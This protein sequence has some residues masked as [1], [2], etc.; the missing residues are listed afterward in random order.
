MKRR[1]FFIIP[2]LLQSCSLMYVPSVRSIPLLEE[3][4]EFQGE[5]GTSLNSIYANTAY[6][7]TD[8]IAA[9][10]SGNM[11]YKNFSNR[12]TLF[13]P[14]GQESAGE[15]AHRYAEAS[16]GA[17]NMLHSETPG[18]PILEIFGGMG[19]GRATAYRSIYGY[20]GSLYSDIDYKNDYYSFFAQGNFGLK[21][22][23]VEVGGSMRLAY[24]QFSCVAGDM[25]QTNFNV[26][27]VEPMGF[28]RVG[29]KNLKFVHRVGFCL[30]MSNWGFE[31]EFECTPYHM[32]IGISY[33]IAGKT[34][35]SKNNN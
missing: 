1:Y 8:H 27:F 34:D 23:I 2:L 21:H 17:I 35:K 30:P 3:K 4:G 29:V 25:F 14:Q 33:R 11:S 5:A 15:Y 18:K 9:A 13:T 32:S 20:R 24:S 7:F 31:G 6:A 19:M 28:V 10:V 26:F 22:R 12:Y 16:V